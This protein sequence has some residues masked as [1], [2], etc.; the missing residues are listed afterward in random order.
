MRTFIQS[1]KYVLTLLRHTQSG[2]IIAIR[3]IPLLS[4]K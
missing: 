3:D 2:A 4:I 1:L